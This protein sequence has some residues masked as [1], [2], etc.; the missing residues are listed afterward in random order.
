MALSRYPIKL[1]RLMQ[2]MPVQ[3]VHAGNAC[4]T[5]EWFTHPIICGTEQV[6]DVEWSRLAVG[7]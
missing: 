1:Q 4:T 3:H 6:V 7:R 5:R 2:G